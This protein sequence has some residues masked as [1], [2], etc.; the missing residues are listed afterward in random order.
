MKYT[1]KLLIA[2]VFCFTSNFDLL[3]NRLVIYKAPPFFGE[4]RLLKPYL[5][6]FEFIAGGGDTEDGFNSSGQKTNILN[7]YG[8][9]NFRN[10]AENV[11]ANVLA[12]NPGCIIN[13]LWQTSLPGFGEVEINGEVKLTEIDLRYYRNFKH[14]FFINLD[15]PIRK[16]Y[17]TDVKYINLS[18]QA[19]AG[20]ANYTD[21]LNFITYLPENMELYGINMGVDRQYHLGDIEF[22]LGWSQAKATG[23]KHLDFWETTLKGGITIPTAP[24]TTDNSPLIVPSGYGVLGFPFS[25]DLALG[26]FEWISIGMHAEGILLLDKYQLYNMKTD[27]EQHGQIKLASGPVHFKRGNI[28]QVGA[29]IKTDHMPWGLSVMLAYSYST[30]QRTTLV[31]PSNSAFS[32]NIINSDNTLNSWRMHTINTSIEYDF[33]VEQEKQ[34]LPRFKLNFD[35]PFGG[36]NVF[37]NMVFSSTV[38][39]DFVW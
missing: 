28:W 30:Q 29:F 8:P 32:N 39:F 17:L 12:R 37:K 5:T 14:G 1:F 4:P 21:W 15:I 27:I 31:L 13:D 25:F 23:H 7:I 2:I 36:K 22:L 34:F 35:I 20:T 38:G 33:A 24:F 3:A 10:M 11:P 6:T 26:L 18:S 19:L 16:L 9:Q